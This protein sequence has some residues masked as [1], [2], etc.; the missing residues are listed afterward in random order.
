MTLLWLP[1][2]PI[3]FP[4]TS[5]ALD[6]PNGLLAAG[7]ELSPEWLLCAY[8]KGIFPWFNEGDPILWW[9]PSPRM[10]LFPDDLHISRSL[11]KTLKKSSFRISINEDFLGVIDGC[12]ACRD[13]EPAINT[14]DTWITPEMKTAYHR[15][16]KM[17]FAHS[18][19]TWQGDSLVG[20]IYGI[21]LGRI[22]FGESMFSRVSDASKVAMVYLTEWLKKWDFKL[23]DC[24]V[25][26]EHLASLGATE[27]SR[28]L[29]EKAIDTYVIEQPD[30]DEQSI[31]QTQT[32][33]NNL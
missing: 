1:P 13:S 8:R 23:I 9:S 15:L 12:M 29:F 25:Y 32:L 17:G 22:F 16:H 10:V 7:G 33:K 5:Q 11:R 27:V 20:G 2:Y 3:E 30:L 31:W 4:D 21:A 6:E 14:S 28:K 18:I 26:S 19:E 24:Q